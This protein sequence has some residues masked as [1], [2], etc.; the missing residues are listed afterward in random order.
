MH[1]LSEFFLC[2]C[3]TALAAAAT[4]ATSASPLLRATPESQGVSSQRLLKVIDALDSQ[5]EGLHSVMIVRHGNVIAEGWWTPYSAEHNH[6]LY[7]LSKSFTSTAVGM[8]IAEGTLHIDDKVLKFFPEDAPEAPDKNL[9]QMRVRDL[10]TMTTGH[11]VEPPTSANEMSAKSFLAQN[12][13]HKPGTHFR[14]NTA[15]T[16]MLSAIIEKQTGQSLID[17]L[18]PRLFEPLAIDHPKW[19]TNAQGIALGGY[20]LRVRTEDIAKLG[21]LYLQEGEWNGR[22]IL[23]KDW[24]A[25]ATSRQV[26]NGSDP[27]SDWG[28]GYGFQFWQCR[29]GAYRG[30]GAF[31]QYC[32]VLPEQ[33]A[34]IAITS[35]LNK[36]QDV[37]D[38]L[39]E[40]LL[41]AFHDVPLPQ[42][43][44]ANKTLHEK[45]ARLQLPVVDGQATGKDNIPG[46]VFHFRE[47]ADNIE[48]LR[49]EQAEKET[50]T[51]ILTIDGDEIKQPCHFGKWALGGTLADGEKAAGSY[52]WRSATELTIKVCACETPFVTTLKLRFDGA[53]GITLERQRNVGFGPRH[54]LVLKGSAQ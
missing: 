28:Q 17:Y 1:R 30:D 8:A 13:P 4:V 40:N 5:I 48:K 15:A 11:E 16:F 43:T 22:R 7:S 19:D 42:A 54:V 20:G 26:S 33:D 49:I 2:A 45:L 24:V 27:D 38:V 51:L 44:T 32:V 14:Y 35:G 29:H 37:L 31:G 50:L 3:M 36:M 53:N 9:Q 12:V 39:W 21:Q 6:V 41:P 52:A 18:T 25:L 47:N 10:L 23:Q 46:A 34:V